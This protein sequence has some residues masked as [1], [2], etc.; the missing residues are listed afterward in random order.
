MLNGETV[1]AIIPARGGS[2]R[3]PGKNLRLY[4]GKPLI[5]WAAMAAQTSEYVDEYCVSSDDGTIIELARSLKI[6]ALR[7]PAYLATD[8]AMNEAVLVHYAYMHEMPDWFVLL[9][10]TSPLR[11]AADIDACLRLAMDGNG[12]VSVRPDGAR[13]GAVYVV[14]AKYLLAT[15]RFDDSITYTMP[16]ERSLDIDFPEDFQK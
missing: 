6:H 1:I 15:L 16:D 10:P 5:Q 2:K 3:C 7:R 9:Q 8:E 12:C 4:R 11:T 13:N 14:R